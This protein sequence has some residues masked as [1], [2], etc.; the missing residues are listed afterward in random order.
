MQRRKD[1]DDDSDHGRPWEEELGVAPKSSGSGSFREVDEGDVAVQFPRSRRARGGP[2]QWGGAEVVVVQQ[3]SETRGGRG[4]RGGGGWGGEKEGLGFGGD[5]PSGDLKEEG[6]V[7][8]GVL[9][10]VC[11]ERFMV[12]AP[13]R[14]TT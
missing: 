4:R 9:A 8:V 10:D 12:R 13:S 3:R 14:K 2:K 5:C 6:E 1:A 11:R 7:V